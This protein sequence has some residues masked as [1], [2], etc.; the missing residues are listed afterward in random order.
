MK[1]K[2]NEATTYEQIPLRHVRM[3]AT[4]G[5]AFELKL[6]ETDRTD[7]HG[8]PYLAYELTGPEGELI[9]S[10]EDFRPSPLSAIDSDSTLRA[11]LGFLTLR[12]GDTDADYFEGYTERQMRFVDEDAEN[13]CLYALADFGYEFEN[14]DDWAE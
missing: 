9:F 14:L 7:R 1:T 6:Y 4:A 12:P 3:E 10:G 5:R 8:Q 11:L 2:T 13:L